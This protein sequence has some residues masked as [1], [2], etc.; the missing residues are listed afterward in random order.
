[1]KHLLKFMMVLLF[2]VSC[3]GTRHEEAV[4]PSAS[5]PLDRFSESSVEADRANSANLTSGQTGSTPLVTFVFDD[6]YDTDYLVARDIFAQE[7][8]VACTAITTDWINKREYLTADQIKELS[9]AGWEIMGHTATHPNLK[10]LS[11]AQIEDELSRS[12]A[13]L[14]GLGLNVR[15]IVYPYN[16]SNETVREI[17]RK[18]YRSGRGGKNELN[19][20]VRNPYDLRSVS[21]RT[22]DV[23]EMKSFI[24]RADAE[25]N[26]LII[27]HHQIDAKA[28]LTKKQGTFLEGEQLLF[29]PSGAWGRHRRDAWFL[30]AGSLHFIP[31]EG[32]PQPGDR[33]VGAVS[34]AS[35][36]IDR[37]VYDQRT[38]IAD[39]IRYIHTQHPDMRIVT[40]DQAL[41]ILGVP[42]MEP[43]LQ[44]QSAG[45][46][47]AAFEGGHSGT[48]AP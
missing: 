5:T 7:G 30:T 6:G 38:E 2:L 10:S 17:A 3:A 31:L 40:I 4:V 13:A 9:D 34:E 41:D 45:T 8:A 36:R 43:A 1:M 46:A 26:W 11:S 44:K 35:A 37:M 28:T 27:Y 33:V 24:D 22:H 39:L 32:L 42:D 15:N 47:N 12:K 25:K 18:Y 23:M 19:R 14:E 20:D 29:T 21:N 48:L 16:K